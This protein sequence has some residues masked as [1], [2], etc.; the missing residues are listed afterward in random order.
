MKKEQNIRIETDRAAYT[1]RLQNVP[2]KKKETR[3]ELTE[4][5]EETLVEFTEK[6]REEIRKEIAYPEWKT[7]IQEEIT[8]QERCT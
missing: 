2:D 5:I 6:Q 7:L 3:E 1:I 8:C 4:M